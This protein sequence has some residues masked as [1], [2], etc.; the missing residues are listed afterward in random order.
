MDPAKEKWDV[1]N[2]VDSEFPSKEIIAS[3]D[4]IVLTGSKH[5]AFADD[6]WIGISA[7][8]AT[9]AGSATEATRARVQGAQAEDTGHLFRPPARGHCIW[10]P[11]RSSSLWMGSRREDAQ[12]Y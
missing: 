8:Y 9:H 12:V 1:F 2:V 3:Y 10:G 6:E 7:L 5:D 4:G 11:S